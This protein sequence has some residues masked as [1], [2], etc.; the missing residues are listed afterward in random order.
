MPPVKQGCKLMNPVQ[1][2]WGRL[3]QRHLLTIL[4]ERF[5]RLEVNNDSE[6]V[7][8]PTFEKSRGIVNY[9]STQDLVRPPF[10][11]LA[12]GQLSKSILAWPT[13]NLRLWSAWLTAFEKFQPTVCAR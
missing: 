12:R 9:D 3:S 10:V 5:K 4:W 2:F 8:V 1:N 11:V 7:K 13:K 6:A